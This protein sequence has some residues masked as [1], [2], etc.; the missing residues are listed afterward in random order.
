MYLEIKKEVLE[1]N[2]LLVMLPT[3]MMIL[4]L[5]MNDGKMNLLKVIHLILMM[6]MNGVKLTLQEIK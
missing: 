5:I 3:Y 4:K 6:K 1:I 2:I